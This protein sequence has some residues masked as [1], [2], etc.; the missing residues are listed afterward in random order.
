M[1][2]IATMLVSAGNSDDGPAFKGRSFRKIIPLVA[3]EYS[4]NFFDS[5]S[6][7]KEAL[8]DKAT[9]KHRTDVAFPVRSNASVRSFVPRTMDLQAR[10][11]EFRK[12][13]N[14]LLMKAVCEDN[15]GCFNKVGSRQFFTDN[16]EFAYCYY[17][18]TVKKP[19]LK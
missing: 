19:R 4:A 16:E 12:K 14:Y 15:G 11:Y 8:V 5:L 17:F 6:S 10:S 1:Q 9:H 3:R 18:M 13:G 7:D 2:A